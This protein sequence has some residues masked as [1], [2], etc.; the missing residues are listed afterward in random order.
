MRQRRS[1][2]DDVPGFANSETTAEIYR[3][4]GDSFFEKRAY[5]Q[6]LAVCMKTVDLGLSLEPSYVV[7]RYLVAKRVAHVARYL[8]KLHEKS[9][10][11]REHTALL[12]KRYT[13]LKDTFMSDM[14]LE[15]TPVYQYDPGVAIEVLKAAGYYGLAAAVA[16]K[17]E[18][19][20]H[21]DYIRIVLEQFRSYSKAVECIRGFLKE[22]AG[23]MLLEHGRVLMRHAPREML[24]LVRDVCGL[25]STVYSPPRGSAASALPRIQDMLPAFVVDLAQL[26]FFV[27]KLLVGPRCMPAGPG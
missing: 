4:H 24:Q 2:S 20:R 18:V 10:A 25:G 27:Q 17:P 12:V 6:A 22:H 8:K 7:E 5:D 15:H 21:E 23:K 3:M 26:E 14:S 1:A 16:Q 13:K 9:L 19:D 11:E